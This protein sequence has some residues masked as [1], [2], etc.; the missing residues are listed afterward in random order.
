MLNATTC[1]YT[2]LMILFVVEPDPKKMPNTYRASILLLLL[3]ISIQLTFAQTTSPALE[4]RKVTE[5]D[6]ETSP[7]QITARLDEF[8][9]AVKNEPGSRGWLYYYSGVTL[10]GA[11]FRLKA[12]AEKYLQLHGDVPLGG[13]MGGDRPISTVE[14]WLVPDGANAPRPT[15]AP[16]AKDYR[17]ALLWDEMNYFPSNRTAGAN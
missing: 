16:V 17:D 11:A 6:A 2:Y 10:P 7:A 3:V 8:A 5:I 12:I 4:A 9:A 15:P 1:Q 13:T 14:F